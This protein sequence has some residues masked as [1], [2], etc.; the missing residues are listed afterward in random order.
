MGLLNYPGIIRDVKFSDSW[1]RILEGSVCAHRMSEYSQ[2]QYALQCV[3]QNYYSV[4]CRHM[5]VKVSLEHPK[6]YEIRYQ[7]REHQYDCRWRSVALILCCLRRR[8]S[9][10][11]LSSCDFGTISGF[12]TMGE[13]TVAANNDNKASSEPTDH[14]HI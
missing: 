11:R 10:A 2:V 6:Q 8:T 4:R 12:A 9:C 14:I 1:S 13:I 5:T 3:A 7:L